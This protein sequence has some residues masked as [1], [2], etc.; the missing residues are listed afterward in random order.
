M[1]LEP[2]EKSVENPEGV[3]GEGERARSPKAWDLV[4]GL[5]WSFSYF[6]RLMRGMR[7]VDAQYVVLE[8]L[9]E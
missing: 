4:M 8:C 9:N 7:G 2:K 3:S 6:Q 5:F 1:S